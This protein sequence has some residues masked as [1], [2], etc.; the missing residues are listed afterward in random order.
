MEVGV[1]TLKPEGKAV[2]A[3]W[4]LI[5]IVTP[6]YNQG[7]FL[8]RCILSV[9]EQDYPRVEYVIVDGG[10][11]DGSVDIIRKYAAQISYW[12]SE[13]D[14]GQS[15]AI[16]KGVSKANG[17]LVAWINADD[18][19]YPGAFRAMAEAYRHNPS[20]PF[21]WG[22]GNKVD[23]SENCL[24]SHYPSERIVFDRNAL[25]EGLNYIL[26]PATFINMQFVSGGV[27]LDENLHYGMDTDLWIRLSA[28]ALPLRIEA[29]I[30]VN[31][32]YGVT[33]T[34]TGGFARAEELRQIAK[35]Y[36][37][38]DLTMGSI[39]YYLETLTRHVQ[40]HPESY[41]LLYRH[42]IG[43][44]FAATQRLL[45][46]QGRINGM[47]P[48]EDLQC[49]DLFWFRVWCRDVLICLFDKIAI[50]CLRKNENG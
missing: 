11:T 14:D 6:S 8:E 4:P 27:L 15:H 46:R 48:S 43:S 19:Y 28:N 9:L 50:R 10:S 21:Y 49:H 40:A 23:E 7:A 34:S 45:E 33:K 42:M 24:G 31:R 18:F 47:F 26:Q 13:Q 44:C 25:Q 29:L 30:A 3:A 41:H 2:P 36:T 20:A 5:S 22:N 35:R 32:E 12:V 38:K 39:W 37:G 17:N 16:N 1:S